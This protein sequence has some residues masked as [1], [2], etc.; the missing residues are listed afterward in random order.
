M[1][2]LF[3]FIG[4]F[5]FA[6]TVTQRPPVPIV[7]ADQGLSNPHSQLGSS[8]DANPAGRMP[9]AVMKALDQA[10]N[11]PT[12]FEA[13][14]KAAELYYQIQR[15]DDAIRYLLK[16]NRLRPDAFEIIADLAM[17]NMEGRHFDTAEKWYEAALVKE[18]DNIAV[19]EGYCAALFQQRKWKAAEDAVARLGNLDPTNRNLLR[20]RNRL[21]ELK[22]DQ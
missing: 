17:M 15:Y 20:F 1:G 9:E 22:G 16:A 14:T 8:S 4:G 11:E 13:Q 12:N 10:R 3:G 5:M 19:L 18:P 21:T 6:S 2:V 7:A